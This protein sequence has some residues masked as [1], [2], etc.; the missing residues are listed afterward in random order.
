MRRE[1]EA[2]VAHETFCSGRSGAVEQLLSRNTMVVAQWIRGSITKYGRSKEYEGRYYGRAYGDRGCVPQQIPVPEEGN[3]C[4]PR[5]ERS[6][7]V[8]GLGYGCE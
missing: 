5:I 3:R 4:F 6:D 7:F 8:K 1:E 2:E